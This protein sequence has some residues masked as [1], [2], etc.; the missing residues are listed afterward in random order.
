MQILAINKNNYNTNNLKTLNKTNSKSTSFGTRKMTLEPVDVN[1]FKSDI[2]K[3]I[4]N[5]IQKYTKLLG[6]EGSVKDVKVFKDE[7][8]I[9]LSINKTSN[10]TKI[11][12]YDKEL[13][14]QNKSSAILEAN[15]D[16]CGQMILGILPND[17]LWFERTKTTNVRRIHDRFNTYL[18]AGYND[19]EWSLSV[20][21]YAPKTDNVYHSAFEIF[22][23]LA[24][25]NT[26][27]L[28]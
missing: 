6:Q 20:K 25:L 2:T 24:R 10:N 19:R 5:K 26:S 4:Y 23:Q 27:V 15:L 8:F 16:N 3:I 28:K 21:S 12:L 14:S 9:R 7:D 22:M 11:T 1:S 13:E 17:N 18:P